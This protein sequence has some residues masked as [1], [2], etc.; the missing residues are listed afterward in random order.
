M[1]LLLLALLFV[2]SSIHLDPIPPEAPTV[3]YAT[4]VTY[5]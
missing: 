4:E 3:F 2:S 1:S 5:E